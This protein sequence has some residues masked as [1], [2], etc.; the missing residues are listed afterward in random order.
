MICPKV[1][2]DL[3]EYEI[4]HFDADS[5]DLTTGYV[6]QESILRN[7][8]SAG[9]F[10]QILEIFSTQKTTNINLSENF[11]PDLGFLRTSLIRPFI[12]NLE[13]YQIKHYL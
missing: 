5:D 1:M 6:D 9:N 12:K 4:Y 3:S 2:Y 7:S 13:C 10:R 11:G 8:I